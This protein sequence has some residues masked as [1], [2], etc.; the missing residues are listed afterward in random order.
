MKIFIIFIG[1]TFANSLD[2]EIINNLYFYINMDI[3]EGE[4]SPLDLHL[5]EDFK[6]S[7]ELNSD[8]EDEN[9]KDS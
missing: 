9:E 8:K 7:E 1:L 5:D 4:T 6:K 2:N 3:V